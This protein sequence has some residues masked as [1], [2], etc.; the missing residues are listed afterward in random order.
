MTLQVCKPQIIQQLKN[1]LH[2]TMNKLKVPEFLTCNKHNLHTMALYISTHRNFPTKVEH[3][4][5][6]ALHPLKFN[7]KNNLLI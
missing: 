7:I 4:L 2:F 6:N 5:P 1:M 3:H